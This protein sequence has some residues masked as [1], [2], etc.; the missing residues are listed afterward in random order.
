M[1][2]KGFKRQGNLNQH[3]KTHTHVK[4]HSRAAVQRNCLNS[5][6]KRSVRILNWEVKLHVPLT[7]LIMSSQLLILALQNVVKLLIVYR[8]LEMENVHTL[9][10]RKLWSMQNCLCL[11]VLAVEYVTNWLK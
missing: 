4:Q 5:I 6:Q 9:A 8:E 7:F 10:T 3:R 11:N 1:C 2:N